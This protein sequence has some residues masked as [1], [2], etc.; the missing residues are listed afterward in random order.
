MR[1]AKNFNLFLYRMSC[2]SYRYLYWFV[3]YSH[4]TYTMCCYL[5]A[6]F[7]GQRVKIYWYWVDVWQR[8]PVKECGSRIHTFCVGIC[9]RNFD[10]FLATN[11]FTVVVN[12]AA[13]ISEFWEKNETQY[14]WRGPKDLRNQC[15][16]QIIRYWPCFFLKSD[17]NIDSTWHCAANS[18]TLKLYSLFFD[19]NL[20]HPSGANSAPTHLSPVEICNSY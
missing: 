14:V 8:Q 11:S 5:N 20:R 15:R 4:F 12:R 19:K 2:I 16:V 17:S 13:R 7:R 18:F 1:L 6:H 3:K 10:T 9:R